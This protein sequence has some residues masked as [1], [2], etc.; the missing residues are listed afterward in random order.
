MCVC[1]CVLPLTP[2]VT[3][4]FYQVVNHT[5]DKPVKTEGF[6]GERGELSV[7]DSWLKGRGF[8][9]WQERRENVHTHTR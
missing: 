3:G 1:V 2:R 4:L 5:L 6:E 8:D 9:S 7:P